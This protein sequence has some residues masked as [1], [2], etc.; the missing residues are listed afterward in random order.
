ML[1]L[2]II[3]EKSKNFAAAEQSYIKAISLDEKSLPARLALGSF[4]QRQ[5][6]WPDAEKEYQAAIALDPTN[7]YPRATLAALYLS[8]G[9]KDAAEK[10]LQDAKSGLK[11]N[12]NA[13]RMLAE[14]YLGERD[15]DKA[16]GELNSLHTQHPKDAVVSR[17]YAEL[18]LQQSKI[19]EASKVVDD[20]LKNSPSDSAAQTL[21][22]Q[23]LIRQGKA[24]DA[25]HV[26]EQVVKN[27]PDNAAAHYHLGVAYAATQNLGQAE[28]E[29]RQA[30]KLQPNTAE[31]LRALASLAGRRND[32]A[33]LEETGGRLMMI[34]P[35]SPEGYIIH[36]QG[37]YLKKD[38]PGT[39]ADLK[40]AISMAPQ[41]PAGYSRLGDLRFSQKK[42]DEAGQFYQEALA[43]NP[44]DVDAMTGLVNISLQKKDPAGALRILQAQIAK[45]PPTSAF[46]VLLGQVEMRNQDSAKAEAAFQKATE[47]DPNN[48]TAFLMLASP[49]VS[50]GSGI[51]PSTPI[52]ARYR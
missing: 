43:R 34:E 36:A 20:F 22:G 7:P 17:M 14:F 6:R 49:Q 2:G 16:L 33:L 50:R 19:D 27:S 24:S 45:A 32:Q 39:E 37:L 48:M 47:L 1:N 23:L 5:K 10:T 13:Y 18:L 41:N 42:Y 52:T 46:Y 30:A 25:V 31:P 28:A 4:Y 51:R 8:E 38:L 11:D 29:W 15:F 26:L 9:Q 21:H 12:P 3:Q 35:G 44:A 40:R